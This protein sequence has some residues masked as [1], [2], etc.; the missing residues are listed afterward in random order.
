MT[1]TDLLLNAAINV[2]GG[3]VASVLTLFGHR[4]LHRRKIN[5]RLSRFA[6]DYTIVSNTPPRDTSAERVT[7]Q[8]V[9]GLR[10]TITATGGPTGDWDGN[11]VVSEDFLDVAHGFYRYP[12]STDWG[13]HELLFHTSSDSIFVYGVNRSKPGLMDPFSFTFVRRPPNAHRKAR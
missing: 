10:F 1:T 12:G 7:I 3:I 8:H 5:R 6:G 11:F 2:V 4:Q 13:Q 9:D